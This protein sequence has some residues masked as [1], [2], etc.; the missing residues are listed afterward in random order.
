[1]RP[2]R[3]PQTPSSGSLL[4]RSRGEPASFAAFYEAYADRVLAFLVRRVIDPELAFDLLSETFAKALASRDQF[5]GNSAGE[6]QGWLFAIARSELYMY[7]RTGNIE[8][9]ALARYAI[10]VP[11]L[12]DQEHERIEALAGLSGA[13]ETLLD[14]MSALP[15]DQRR[16][17]ELRVL[18]DLSYPDLAATLDVSE[19]TA[20]ARVSRGLRALGRAVRGAP[21]NILGERA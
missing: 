12:S 3:R 19:A 21:G 10:T 20:R 18:E 13:S 4:V 17:V 1:V 11:E 16:A 8:R 7:W 2:R 14:A 15:A 5:R 9:S 6:E